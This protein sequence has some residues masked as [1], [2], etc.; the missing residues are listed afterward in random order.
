MGKFYRP[1]FV[2][3]AILIP[4]AWGLGPSCIVLLDLLTIL[5]E[6]LL[7]LGEGCP[8]LEDLI[9]LH[10]RLAPPDLG[11]LLVSFGVEVAIQIDF[12]VLLLEKLGALVGIGGRPHPTIGACTSIIEAFHLGELSTLIGVDVVLAIDELFLVSV[13]VLVLPLDDLPLAII[14]E[15]YPTSRD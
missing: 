1:A 12:E 7:A 5:I 10:D 14:G 3:I 13:V 6:V 8:T 9:S 4:H 15:D 11:I 2:V